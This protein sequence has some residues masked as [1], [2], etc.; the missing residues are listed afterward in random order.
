MVTVFLQAQ[1]ADYFQ[2]MMSTMGKLFAE[3]IKIGKMI[4]NGLK[5][6]RILSHAAFKA[7]SPDVQNGSEGLINGNGREE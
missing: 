6:G 5:T 1:Q 3:A 4:E 2:N 7:T